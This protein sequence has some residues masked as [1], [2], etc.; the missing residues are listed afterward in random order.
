MSSQDAKTPKAGAIRVLDVDDAELETAG[1]E[2]TMPRQ[3]ST[4]SM[5]ALSFDLTATWLGVGA[6]LGI[7]LQESSA[8][9]VVWPPLIAGVS[10]VVLAS[11]IAELASAYPVAG[12]QYYWSFMVSS[13]ET[14]PFWAFLNGWMSVFGWWLG[15][16]A[17]ANL[18]AGQF[19]AIAAF[20]NPG[21]EIQNWHQYLVAVGNIWLA[22]AFNIFGSRWLPLWNKAI[23]ILSTVL[24]I[25]TFVAI[26]VCSRNHHAS[27]SWIFGD[28]TN[29]TGWPSDGFAFLLAIMNGVFSYSGVDAAAHMCEELPNPGR[30]VPKAIVW[31]VIL[32]FITA[33]PFAIALVASIARMDDVLAS[34]FPLLEVYYQAT[35]SKV[36]A[37]V[38]LVFFTLCFYGVLVAVATTCSRTLW[39]I[40]RDGALPYSRI[41]AQVHP[42]WKVPVNSILLCGIAMSVRLLLSSQN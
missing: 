8:V 14:A 22:V 41:W 6:T 24:M 30:N 42:R 28:A 19:L 4:F 1:Y 16:S 23:M 32:S 40:S 13:P 3:W 37:T 12:A 7:A 39:A 9:G 10:T 2:R 26:L 15:F 11:G 20:W 35:G 25:V 29:S 18:I 34:S 33:F 38:L 21:Y 17:C 36:G 5:V 27:A 31:P